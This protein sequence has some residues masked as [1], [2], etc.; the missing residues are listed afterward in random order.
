MLFCPPDRSQLNR[1]T[2]DKLKRLKITQAI[3]TTDAQE[4]G[5]CQ[6]AEIHLQR[7]DAAVYLNVGSSL[8]G[9]TK[10]IQSFRHNR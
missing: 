7:P 3:E 4:K 10:G 5:R 1:S 6:E 2:V 8:L 9:G